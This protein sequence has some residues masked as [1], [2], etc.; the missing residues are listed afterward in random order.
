MSTCVYRAE[1]DK[2]IEQFVTDFTQLVTEKG[3]TIHNDGKMAM[4][5]TFTAHGHEVVEGFDLHMIQLC[6][7]E[8]QLRA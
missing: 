2:S 8:R 3:F 7:P 4:K 6:K 1:S 5:D